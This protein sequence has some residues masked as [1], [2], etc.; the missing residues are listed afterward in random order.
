MHPEQFRSDATVNRRSHTVGT[1]TTGYTYPLDSHRLEQVGTQARTF[2][3]SGNTLTGVSGYTARGLRGHYD[4]R[5]RL[6][7]IGD[8]FEQFSA[9]WEYNGRGERVYTRVTDLFGPEIETD[10][11]YAYDESGQLIGSYRS[12]VDGKNFFRAEEIVWLDNTPVARVVIVPSQGADKGAG[13][14]IE[15][16]AI[17]TDHLNTPRALVNAQTQGNQPAGTVIWRWRLVNQGTSG[18]NAFGAMAAEEDPDGNGTTVRFDL[19][20]PGQQY[21]ASTGLH[22]NYFRDYEAGT[23]RY[24]ESDP[25]GLGG[26]VGTYGYA[27]Q[28]STRE[29]DPLG[30]EAFN[31]AWLDPIGPPRGLTARCYYAV[32]YLLTEWQRDLFAPIQVTTAAVMLPEFGYG[33]TCCVEPEPVSQCPRYEASPYSDGR[34]REITI[35]KRRFGITIGNEAGLCVSYGR[36]LSTGIPFNATQETFGGP[37]WR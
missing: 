36:G 26:G 29:I 8:L 19:R 35:G 9:R 11:R 17:H 20:F 23:G 24:V 25:F 18:S 2:D 37:P 31:P 21:D 14:T 10:D 34:P 4:H 15:V 16:H 30:L 12:V 27:S 32:N 3:A 13:A 22:Y 6:S 7:H 33:V 28:N 5:N 1:S